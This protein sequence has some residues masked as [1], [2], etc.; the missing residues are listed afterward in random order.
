M[1]SQKNDGENSRED[2]GTNN[3]LKRMENNLKEPT[4]YL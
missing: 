1:R 3:A 2:G 4:K